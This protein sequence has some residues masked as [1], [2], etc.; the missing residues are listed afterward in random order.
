VLIGVS[1]PTEPPSFE[2]S[3][4]PKELK[5]VRLHDPRSFCKLGDDVVVLSFHC[6]VLRYDD[7]FPHEDSVTEE[8]WPYSSNGGRKYVVWLQVLFLLMTFVA[9]MAWHSP[10]TPSVGVTGQVQLPM[11]HKGAGVRRVRL[12][13]TIDDGRLRNQV[14]AT[15]ASVEP[16]A[17]DKLGK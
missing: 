7:A 3:C 8:A 17:V 2:F 15:I 1:N 16:K 12:G 5:V 4:I 10:Q 13:D 9:S 14:D 6:D 11:K